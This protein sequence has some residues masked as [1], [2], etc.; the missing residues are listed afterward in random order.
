MKNILSKNHIVK[1]ITIAFFS[2]LISFISGFFITTLINKSCSYY[3]ASFIYNGEKD[4]SLI[5]DKE[6]L[7]SIKDTNSKNYSS[8]N[9]TSLVDNKDISI[10]K[11]DNNYYT[12]TTKANYFDDFFYASKGK[13]DTRAKTFIKLA[14][15]NYIEDNETIVF[16]DSENIVSLKNNISPYLGGGVGLIC[17]IFLSVIVLAYSKNKRDESIEDNQILFHTPF[18]KEYWK[19]TFKAFKNTKKMVILAMLFSLLLVSKYITIP[20]GFGELG[21][22]FGFIFLSIIALIYGP[23]T[24]LIIGALSDIIGYYITIQTGPMFVGYTVQAS[25]ACFTYSLCFYRTKIS[26]TKVLLSRLIVNILLNVV[27]GSFI[28]CFIYMQNG[29]INQDTYMKTV[30]IYMLSYELP[31]NIVYLLPQT[32]L[33]FVILKSIMP[34]LSRFNLVDSRIKDH[35]SL[36]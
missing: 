5:I 18:H 22:K 10:I 17:G 4:L 32:M 7:Q 2:L 35:M 29:L 12:I 3:Q 6:Y 25:L 8:I 28:Q 11:E 20:S 24:S 9:I 14:L 16:N 34:I 33:L 26:F 19:D 15:T 23:I 30:E 13:V 36:I 1:I 21:L 31:K 27:L